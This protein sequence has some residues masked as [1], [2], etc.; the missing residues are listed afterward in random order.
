MRAVPIPVVAGAEQ[1][2]TKDAL[3]FVE[4]LQRELG[5]T[6][7]ELLGRRE[8]QSAL[9]AGERPDFLAETRAVREAEWRVAEAPA[10]PAR[11][12]LRDHRPGRPEDDD[13]RAQ[14]GRA[15]LHGRLRGLALADLAERGRGPA[16]RAGRG[17]P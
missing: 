9:D 11:P 17:A 14:L 4:L 1:M 13:Q 7:R 10:G 5:P 8:R 16:E 15:G 12:P 3:E 2:L 6:R